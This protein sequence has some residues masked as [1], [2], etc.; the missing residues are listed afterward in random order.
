MNA[1]PI[2]PMIDPTPIVSLIQAHGGQCSFDEAV[3]AF[4]NLGMSE[5]SARDALW[6]LVSDG[7]VTFTVDR[8]LALPR[9]S[10]FDVA[11]G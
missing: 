2:V 4:R 7:S 1:L 11:A 5:S 6:R 3:L 8:Q 10:R 9:P